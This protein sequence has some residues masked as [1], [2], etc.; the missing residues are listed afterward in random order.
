ML[1][2]SLELEMNKFRSTVLGLEPIR[3]GESGWNMLN[4]QEV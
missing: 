4:H 3:S 1:W 2:A